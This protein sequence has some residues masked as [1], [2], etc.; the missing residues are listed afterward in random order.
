MLCFHFL[1]LCNLKK[2]S[3]QR[4]NF[5]LSQGRKWHRK[6]VKW[7]FLYLQTWGEYTHQGEYSPRVRTVLSTGQLAQPG[8]PQHSTAQHST[9]QVY[10]WARQAG[11]NKMKGKLSNNNAIWQTVEGCTLQGHIYF[12]LKDFKHYLFSKIFHVNKK[13]NI[14][15]YT[16]YIYS[17]SSSSD[18]LSIKFSLSKICW[19]LKTL[20]SL[21]RK[22]CQLNPHSLCKWSPFHCIFN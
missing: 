18:I 20:S 14:P 21:Y 16:K 13:E 15:S 22:W 6:E 9:A 2:Y 10:N 7:C 4:G 17:T 19:M 3:Q 11:R 1:F 5:L 8:G 12:I